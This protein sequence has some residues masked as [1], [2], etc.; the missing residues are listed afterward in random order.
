[1]IMAGSERFGIFP[2]QVEDRERKRLNANVLIFFL[3][4]GSPT[5]EDAY[6]GLEKIII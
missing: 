3:S 1:M 6:N 2:K 4:L 5:V